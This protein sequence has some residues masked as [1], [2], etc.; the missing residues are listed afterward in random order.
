MD[1]SIR[2][3]NVVNPHHDLTDSNRLALQMEAVNTMAKGPLCEDL[4]TLS[5]IIGKCSVRIK[6]AGLDGVVDTWDRYEELDAKIQHTVD[7]M[8]QSIQAIREYQKMVLDITKQRLGEEVVMAKIE[9][10]IKNRG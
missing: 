3:K 8:L 4:R 1:L 2:P 5:G 7:S 6:E 10:I 9:R